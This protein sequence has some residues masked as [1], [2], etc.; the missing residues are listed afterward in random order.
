M[1][2]VLVCIAVGFTAVTPSIPSFLFVARWGGGAK[3]LAHT[4]VLDNAGGLFVSGS[5]YS[6]DFPTTTTASPNGSWC[7]FTTKLS[8]LS[9]AGLYSTILCGRGQTW[10]WATALAPA[11][12]LWV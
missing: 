10:G 4:I 6:T 11:G 2:A 5:T 7:A 1:R 12:E 8:A 3:D 9:G